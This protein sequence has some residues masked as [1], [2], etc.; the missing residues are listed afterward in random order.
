MP[1]IKAVA[2]SRFRARSEPRASAARRLKTGTA[3][4]SIDPDFSVNMVP[5]LNQEDSTFKAG[6]SEMGLKVPRGGIYIKENAVAS[7]DFG[8]CGVVKGTG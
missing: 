4:R 3:E 5:S 2:L 7:K 6:G 8:M 1:S